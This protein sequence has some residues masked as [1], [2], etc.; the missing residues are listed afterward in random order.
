MADGTT[1]NVED[2]LRKLEKSLKES[3]LNSTIGLDPD[4]DSPSSFSFDAWFNDTEQHHYWNKS[5]RNLWNSWMERIP[6]DP[7]DKQRDIGDTINSDAGFDFS[8]EPYV[9]PDLNI[10]NQ[11]YE[12]V[13]G[14]DKIE[15]VLKNK[16]QMQYTHTQNKADGINTEKYIRLLMPKYLRRVEIEDLNRN[17][18]VIA[19]TIGLISEYL[20]SPDSPLNELIKGILKEIAQL[21][22]NVYRIWEALHGLGEKV[23]ETN[24]RINKIVEATQKTKVRINLNIYPNY[25][26][27]GKEFRRMLG[28]DENSNELITIDSISFYPIRAKK[29][30]DN[31]YEWEVGELTQNLKRKKD[32]I[33]ECCVWMNNE[34]GP[35]KK[36]AEECY[37]KDVGYKIGCVI[38]YH[39]ETEDID[40]AIAY[41]LASPY[42]FSKKEFYGPYWY[43]KKIVSNQ[44]YIHINRT[45]MDTMTEENGIYS[46]PVF[47]E[48][49]DTSDQKIGLIEIER[50][51]NNKKPVT[52]ILSNIMGFNFVLRDLAINELG[53]SKICTWDLIPD[54]YTSITASRVSKKDMTG[55]FLKTL[56]N[57]STSANNSYRTKDPNVGENVSVIWTIPAVIYEFLNKMS[58]TTDDVYDNLVTNLAAAKFFLE[59]IKEENIGQADSEDYDNLINLYTKFL[60]N[61]NNESFNNFVL[62]LLRI[63]KLLPSDLGL[64]DT[65]EASIDTP[66]LKNYENAVQAQLSKSDSLAY[67]AFVSNNFIKSAMGTSIP[68]AYLE[69]DHYK[70]E[71]RIEFNI[72]HYTSIIKNVMDGYDGYVEGGNIHWALTSSIVPKEGFIIGGGDIL[73]ASEDDDNQK[74][75]ERQSLE[76]EKKYIGNKKLQDLLDGD[77]SL[78]NY[79]DSVDNEGEEKKKLYV[80]AIAAIGNLKGMQEQGGVRT[81]YI[82][83]YIPKSL[84]NYWITVSSGDRTG[85]RIQIRINYS[86][87]RSFSCADGILG[88]L[89]G[90]QGQ[91]DCF[92]HNTSLSLTFFNPFSNLSDFESTLIN[93]IIRFNA[94]ENGV[95]GVEEPS[96][97]EWY[98]KFGYISESNCITRHTDREDF[99]VDGFLGTLTGVKWGMSVNDRRGYTIPAL[100]YKNDAEN[101]NFA[102]LTPGNYYK[103]VPGEGKGKENTPYGPYWRCQGPPLWRYGSG[104]Y[105]KVRPVEIFSSYGLINSTG[106]Y[107][108]FDKASIQALIGKMDIEDINRDNWNAQKDSFSVQLDF[109]TY[110]TTGITNHNYCIISASKRQKEIQDQKKIKNPTGLGR[111]WTSY[112]G[113]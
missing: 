60:K 9:K 35:Y 90:S 31:S 59:R 105:G 1:W 29:N 27:K 28:E 78:K 48:P 84:N 14:D 49:I 58:T 67:K 103:E 10:D 80:Q 17:F 99:L 5:V 92:P 21:W 24:D 62:A 64:G 104:I 89:N 61:E 36:L 68:W 97:K 55:N 102:E 86:N 30:N 44:A 38:I 88:A 79:F 41:D 53:T 8:K 107:I 95:M 74:C 39:K 51:G 93:Q 96:N 12:S 72:S 71:M 18:W 106:D 87:M 54:D 4:I 112:T 7:D 101:I 13:R 94:P 37:G 75:L 82:Q 98:D 85:G 23:S 16:K 57:F 43:A 40:H 20:L 3:E 83:P 47:N 70:K 19:Q 111:D 81:E 69:A 11:T 77:P 42:V 46:N 63:L 113:G 109:L 2:F 110:A 73:L 50:D 76:D 33:A 108:P 65:L 52:E 66:W 26:D 15:S 6:S 25:T 34:N 56:V 22:D 100:G 91:I 45:I 32:Q